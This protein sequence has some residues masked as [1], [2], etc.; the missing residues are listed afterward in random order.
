MAICEYCERDVD[1]V[2]PYPRIVPSFGKNIALI[3]AECRAALVEYGSCF[4]GSCGR[5]AHPDHHF[6]I[7]LRDSQPPARISACSADHL[8]ELKALMIDFLVEPT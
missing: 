2:A 5:P 1:E 4:Y 8:Q 6:D 3:C 7:D